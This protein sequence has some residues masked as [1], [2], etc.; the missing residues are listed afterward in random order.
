MDFGI[1]VVVGTLV[2]DEV[3]YR[4]LYRELIIMP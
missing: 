4:F 2:I 3:Y 1:S